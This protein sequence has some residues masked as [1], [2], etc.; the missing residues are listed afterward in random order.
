MKMPS[1]IAVPAALVLA[2]AS[3]A[4]AAEDKSSHR[5]QACDD[6]QQIGEAEAC[7]CAARC[8]GQDSEAGDR[9]GSH[10]VGRA[11]HARERALVRGLS[12]QQ[13]QRRLIPTPIPTNR[14]RKKRLGHRPKRLNISGSST[15]ART[16]GP[17]D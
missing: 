16:R 10:S 13:G 6:P 14:P 12:S 2:L 17:T 3:T 1:L 4:T 7:R 9:E 15:W 11:E 5:Q 8:R